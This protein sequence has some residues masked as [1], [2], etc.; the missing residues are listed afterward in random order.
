MPRHFAGDPWGTCRGTKVSGLESRVT[1][2]DA[3]EQPKEPF[4][5]GRDARGRFTKGNPGG[6]GNPAAK[7]VA[8]LRM[9]LLEAVTEDDMRVIV[10]RLVKEAKAGNIQA[11]REV[12]LRTLG[13]PLEADLV[14]RLDEL[15]DILTQRLEAVGA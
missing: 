1:M 5:N 6:P 10:R 7:R 12:L 11:A 2:V 4:G 14:E 15:E 13:R 8:A 3:S 9:A